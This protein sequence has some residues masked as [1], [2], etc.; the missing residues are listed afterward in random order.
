MGTPRKLLFKAWA[1]KCPSIISTIFYWSRSHRTYDRKG[2]QEFGA[3]F[4]V[5][6]VEIKIFTPG[7]VRIKLDIMHSETD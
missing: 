3:I 1:R 6:K 7:A 5:P 2:D 4:N